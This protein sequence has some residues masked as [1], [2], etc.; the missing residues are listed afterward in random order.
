M[1]GKNEIVKERESPEE[2]I[3]RRHPVKMAIVIGSVTAV[4]GAVA[5]GLV[6]NYLQ[7]GQIVGEIARRFDFVDEGGSPNDAL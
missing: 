5:G 3:N 2:R 6:T 1:D 4:I 7:G